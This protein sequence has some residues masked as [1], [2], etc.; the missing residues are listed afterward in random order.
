MQYSVMIIGAGSKGAL[1]DAPDTENAKKYI[2]YAHAVTDH[3]G[4][5][6]AGF[7][8]ILPEMKENAEKIWGKGSGTPEVAVI[9]TP[10]N[11]H[12]E[13]L[14]EL[15]Y[16]PLRLVICEKPICTKFH[17]AYEIVNLYEKK[18]TPI[19]CDYTRRFIPHW[20]EH[21]RAIDAGEYGKL[22]YGCGIFNDSYM[23]PNISPEKKRWDAFLHSG[24]HMID[25][26]LWLTGN[27]DFDFRYIPSH[28]KWLYQW[29]FCYE[30][31][32]VSETV[33]DFTREKVNTIY[34][35]HLMYVMQNA[36]GFLE[37]KEKLI[38]TGWD[39]FKTLEKTYGHMS[40]EERMEFE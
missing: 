3:P 38:C 10:D 2:S 28:Y 26:A 19:L 31:S 24:S 30:H 7:Y 29:T 40:W 17:E 4:F 27:A 13:Y 20:Q 14:K 35:N 23:D 16:M 22:I 34:D 37:G 32:H 21:K 15:A 9:T 5:S 12:Y 39:A 25:T 6:L 36:Y 8:D 11:A 18:G 33:G 1:C